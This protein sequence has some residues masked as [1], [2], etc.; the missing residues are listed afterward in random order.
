MDFR[1]K[2]P[3]WHSIGSGYNFNQLGNPQKVQQLKLE[4]INR[5]FRGMVHR[6]GLIQID[7]DKRPSF[8]GGTHDAPLWCDWVQYAVVEPSIPRTVVCMNSRF[9]LACLSLSTGELRICSEPRVVRE[10]S[11]ALRFGTDKQ[12]V[13]LLA[14]N[15]IS[16]T[17]EGCFGNGV[18]PKL[19]LPF[20]LY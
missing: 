15:P 16:L 9:V 5:S 12:H 4:R 14:D 1:M 6:S 10:G 8:Q 3:L 18:K 11:F 19:R 2:H 17:L 13:F 7:A 20:D